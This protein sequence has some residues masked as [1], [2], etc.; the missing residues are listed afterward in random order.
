M[1][2]KQEKS[3]SE[4][5]DYC[6][7]ICDNPLYRQYG[8]QSHPNEREYGIFLFCIHGDTEARKH[9]QEVAGHGTFKRSDEKD[10]ACLARAYGIIRAKFCGA[11]L[12][13]EGQTVEIPD[14]DEI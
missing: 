8:N 10:E 14:S 9:P 5:T 4:S 12:E 2:K 13:T 3:G 11:K 6:C 7:P 1:K